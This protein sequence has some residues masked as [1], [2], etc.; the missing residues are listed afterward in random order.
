MLTSLVVLFACSPDTVLMHKL[1]ESMMRRGGQVQVWTWKL[2][3]LCALDR[4]THVHAYMHTCRSVEDAGEM[5]RCVPGGRRVRRGRDQRIASV[6]LIRLL[7]ESYTFWELQWSDV[8]IMNI[9]RRM[10]EGLGPMRTMGVN[11]KLRLEV[12]EGSE[13]EYKTRVRTCTTMANAR[14]PCESRADYMSR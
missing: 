14:K 3:H 7:R 12:S 6:T 4:T 10:C 1:V 8:G 11:T 5:C 13:R 9:Y 2:Y